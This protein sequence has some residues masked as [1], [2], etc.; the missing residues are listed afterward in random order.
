LVSLIEE[1]SD[2]CLNVG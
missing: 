1:G 2:S